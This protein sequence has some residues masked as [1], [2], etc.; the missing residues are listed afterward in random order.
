MLD[1]G[2]KGLRKVVQSTKLLHNS[3][4]YFGMNTKASF[5]WGWGLFAAGTLG[6]AVYGIYLGKEGNKEREIENKLLKQRQ[7]QELERIAA[8]RVAS[9]KGL[10]ILGGAAQG[11]IDS[12][13]SDN[14]S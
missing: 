10:G 9:G 5:V 3:L 13:A 7:Q 8:K 4:P 6:G 1:N 14:S 11:S 2:R 12:F